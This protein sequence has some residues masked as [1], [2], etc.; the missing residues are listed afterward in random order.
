L[1][2]KKSTE[3]AKCQKKTIASDR[4]DPSRRRVDSVSAALFGYQS[5]ATKRNM[6]S[7]AAT[8]LLKRTAAPSVLKRTATPAVGA[9]RNINLHEYQSARIM[10]ECGVNVP[11]GIPA[12]TVQQ[13]VDAAEKIGDEDVVIKSQILAGGRGLGKFMDND[14]GTPGLQVC[15]FRARKLLCRVPS[16]LASAG[17][18]SNFVGFPSPGVNRPKS[19][20]GRVHYWF[21]D[22][23]LMLNLSFA[24][25]LTCSDKSF[26]PYLLCP[27]KPPHVL[28][29]RSSRHPDVR[30]PRLCRQ[31]AGQDARDQAER[32]RR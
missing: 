16:L 4:S 6:L 29:G 12:H 18:F 14:D 20:C 3:E 28:K 7:S 15:V 26:V 13:A 17:I 5:Q 1:A 2:T 27:A 30:G 23:E 21:V 32:S 8:T 11:F 9:V 22:D 24:C 10:G 19:Q 31:D 25:N